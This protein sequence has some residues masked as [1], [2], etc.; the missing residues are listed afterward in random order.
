MQAHSTISNT[1]GA[2]A[3]ML[4][5]MQSCGHRRQV[6]SIRCTRSLDKPSGSIGKPA[7]AC[8]KHWCE[9]AR[10]CFD[11]RRPQVFVRLTHV[12]HGALR[13]PS[14]QAARVGR[15]CERCGHGRMGDRCASHMQPPHLQTVS[16]SHDRVLA[17][18]DSI[19]L[20]AFCTMCARR[21]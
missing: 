8:D 20:A 4:P 11:R 18:T 15:W 13:Q 21:C 17:R 12:E 16:D 14:V 1:A 2:Q 5:C 6:V 9:R 3:D 19:T 7:V 10:Q